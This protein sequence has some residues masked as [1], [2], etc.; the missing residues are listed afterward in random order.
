MIERATGV[1]VLDVRC[2]GSIDL[3]AGALCQ[4]RGG[5]DVAKIREK[6]RLHR[7][8]RLA[9]WLAPVCI[10]LWW[11][12]IADL[13]LLWFSFRYTESEKQLLPGF[14]LVFVLGA[15]IVIPMMMSGR[16]PHI[17]YQPSEIKTGFDDVVGARVVKDEVVRTL[18]LFLAYKT[19]RERMGGNPRKAMLFEGPPGTG[20]TYMAKAMAKEAGVPFFF[21]S[22][23]AFQSHFYGMTSHKIRSFFKELRR[24]AREEGGAIGFIEE[25]DAIA[26]ARSGMNMAPDEARAVEPFGMRVNRSSSEGISGVVNE[27]LVQLQS[28]DTPT[29][30]Q[31]FRGVWVEGV[32]KWLPAKLQLKKPYVEAPNILVIGATNRASDLDPALMRPGRFDRSIHFGLPSRTDRREIIDYYLDRKAH[33]PEL[34]K[35]ERREQF[36]AMTLGYSPVMIE[37]VFDESLVWALRAGREAMNWNDLN[38]AKLTEEIGLKQ[39]VEYTVHEKETIATH[40]AGHA[41]VAYLMGGLTHKLEV[42]SIVKRREALGLL[43][44]SDTEERWTRTRSELMTAIHIAFG[45]MTAEELFFGESGTGPSSDLA[46]ATQVAC[47]MVGSFGMAGSLVSFDA[48]ESGPFGGGI[49][50]K[51]LA[52]DDARASVERILDGS[53]DVVRTLL[54]T[55]RHLV[56][57][58]RDALLE[59]DELVGDEI[60]DELRAAEAQ[61]KLA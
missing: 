10:Y 48:I 47:R 31:K 38:Q 60:V 32:N 12:I 33:D 18:N 22:A 37:H 6:T 59:R 57:A 56:I 9:W 21:V 36:A 29:K 46:H 42:L 28:F 51:V 24:A 14:I 50:A 13:P 19:F 15:V 39:P 45:G 8:A 25:I 34:D 17:R 49:V 11:R 4:V 43:A 5:F 30:G 53:K 20:K 27:L 3:G 23:T 1:A 54:D 26:G 7:L 55:N 52:N 2:D 16:S 58:L 44:H 41:V 61:A 40:E 35:P